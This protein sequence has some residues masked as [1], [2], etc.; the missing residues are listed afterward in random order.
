MI[1]KDISDVSTVHY[2]INLAYLS[3]YF[4]VDQLYN[5]TAQSLLNHFIEIQLPNLAVADKF[6]DERFADEESAAFEMEMVINSTK[7]SAQVYDNLA[8]YLFNQMVKAH[9]SQSQFDLLSPFTWVT[10]FSWIT[11][12]VAL[13]LALVIILRIRMHSLTMMMTLHTAQAAPTL[14]GIISM[15]H[16][17]VVTE[18]VVDK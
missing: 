11:S 18:S 3:E 9:D 13:A 15:T 6:L 12:I 8:H 5:L 17:T 16:L 4:S 10:I 1:Q 2:S 7:S 14:P